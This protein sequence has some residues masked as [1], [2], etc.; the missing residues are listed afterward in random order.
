M[1]LVLDLDLALDLDLVLDL[2]LDLDLNENG[3][4]NQI[5]STKIFNR[6][7]DFNRTNNS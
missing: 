6:L 1:D 5:R 4:K 2:D 3:L 7:I